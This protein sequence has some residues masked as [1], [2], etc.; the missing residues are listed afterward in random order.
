MGRKAKPPEDGPSKE[1][2]QWAGVTRLRLLARQEPRGHGTT[3]YKN[4]RG[5]QG[6]NGT[7]CANNSGL[8]GAWFLRQGT[9]T[10]RKTGLRIQIKGVLG[11]GLYILH[12]PPS[13]FP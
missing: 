3:M 7:W 10:A 4:V 2:I 1:N 11:K 12:Y 5:R 13:L 8:E 9:L 6:H